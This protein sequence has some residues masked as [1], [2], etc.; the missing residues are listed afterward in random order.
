MS[1]KEKLDKAGELLIARSY[2]YT[3]KM[4]GEFGRLPLPYH[5]HLHTLDVVAA[6]GSLGELAMAKGKISPKELALLQIAAAG[7]DLVHGMV[8]NGVNEQ[9]S[10]KKLAKWMIKQTPDVF[11]KSLVSRVENIIMATI[12]GVNQYGFWQS[13][14]EDY[15]GQLM[16]DADVSAAGLPPYEA[17]IRSDRL[18]LESLKGEPP[19][20]ANRLT[21]LQNQ[22]IFYSTHNWYTEEAEVLLPYQERNL[23][24][25]L[26]EIETLQA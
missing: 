17:K 15:L 9:R 25:T 2:A 7:H 22:V 6:A 11:K 21:F 14:G 16:C 13:A 1:R 23:H 19:E 24:M 5:N 4:Y 18:Y 26:A 20:P 3:R 12:C 8:G 10:A